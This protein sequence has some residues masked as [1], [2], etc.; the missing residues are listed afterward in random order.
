MEAVPEAQLQSDIHGSTSESKP[1]SSREKN[2]RVPY[3]ADVTDLAAWSS[4]DQEKVTAKKKKKKTSSQSKGETSAVDDQPESSSNPPPSAASHDPETCTAV[5]ELVS[6]NRCL[7]KLLTRDNLHLNLASSAMNGTKQKAV[8]ASAT[9]AS[10]SEEKT[11]LHESQTAA[12]EEFWAAFAEDEETENRKER[13][14]SIS[15]SSSMKRA[16]SFISIYDGAFDETGNLLFTSENENSDGRRG[17]SQ[18]SEISAADLVDIDLTSDVC[19][20]SASPAETLKTQGEGTVKTASSSGGAKERVKTKKTPASEKSTS[21]S[22]CFSPPAHPQSEEA[23]PDS[24]AAA[25]SNLSHPTASARSDTSMDRRSIGIGGSSLMTEDTDLAVDDFRGWW[26]R[27]LA[28]AKVLKTAQ[29]ADDEGKIAR[30]VRAAVCAIISIFGPSWQN[31]L[32]SATKL[33]DSRKQFL[34]KY[35]SLCI[36]I[37]IVFVHI[38]LMKTNLSGYANTPYQVIFVKCLKKTHT[39]TNTHTQHQP[40]KHTP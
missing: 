10:E 11:K 31:C 21:Q 29:Q 32:T 2:V 4:G 18:A 38:V 37:N 19:D 6:N 15:S 14:G 22:G 1:S 33:R 16:S 3:I 30:K 36:L 20:A 9:L 13:G 17:Q 23:S 39:H 8:E 25:G 27:S 5:Q 34:E 12:M 40:T 35:V 26:S 24:R 28:I 7:L